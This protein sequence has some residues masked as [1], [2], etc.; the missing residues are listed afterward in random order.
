[1]TSKFKCFSNSITTDFFL[2][3]VRILHYNPIFA[4]HLNKFILTSVKWQSYDKRS[5]EV[6]NNYAAIFHVI[7]QIDLS[8]KI[9]INNCIELRSGNGQK[10]YNSI[11]NP[12]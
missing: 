10:Y 8:H 11:F 12:L 9:A 6:S 3:C 4:H 5:Y 7:L 2:T 1:M